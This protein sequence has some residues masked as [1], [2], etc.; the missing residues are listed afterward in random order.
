MLILLS[1]SFGVFADSQI[2]P[3]LIQEC[4]A[5][6]GVAKLFSSG[7]TDSCKTYEQHQK[8]GR[9][10]SCTAMMKADCDCGPDKCYAGGKCV[11][12]KGPYPKDVPRPRRSSDLIKEVDKKS[13]RAAFV[14]QLSRACTEDKFIKINSQGLPK[15]AASI[16]KRI[17]ECNHRIAEK[18]DGSTVPTKKI[19]KGV[20]K[21]KCD[22]LQ[23]DRAEFIK[24]HSSNQNI[25]SVFA[26][27]DAW[28]GYCD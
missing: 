25:E 27:A 13:A 7:C 14:G 22:S 20:K 15:G 18:G 19:E 28:D 21:A 6:G 4:T 23:N 12:N 26:K 5:A 17:L 16:L 11:S 10:V 3:E 9:L 1:S 8:H 24:A 2:S